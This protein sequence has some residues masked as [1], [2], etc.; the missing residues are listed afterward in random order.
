MN[1]FMSFSVAASNV[2]YMFH[3]AEPDYIFNFFHVW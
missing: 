3:L 1:K 2:P